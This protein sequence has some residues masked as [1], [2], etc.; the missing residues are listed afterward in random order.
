MKK[1]VFLAAG[2]T[3]MASA[4]AQVYGELGYTSTSAKIF[5]GG[6]TFKASPRAIRGIIGYETHPNLA[7]EGMYTLGM[8][9]AGLSGPAVR[10]GVKLKL[11]NAYGIYLKPKAKL[12]DAFEVF[13]RIGYVKGKFKVSYLGRSE[14]D[15]DDGL[16]YGVGLSYALSTNT[17]LNLDHVQYVKNSDVKV[18]GT[19]LGIGYRF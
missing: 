13:G 10:S 18:T 16:S 19:T 7:V 8:G 2:V 12:S 6:D 4:Q 17:S 11:D 3:L 9:S 14:S 5:D 1:I 15:S